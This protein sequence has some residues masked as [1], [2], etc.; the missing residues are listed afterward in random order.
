MCG[1]VGAVGDSGEDLLQGAAHRLLH[2]GP[3]AGG[4]WTEG[5]VTLAH[6]RLEVI[7]LGSPGTQPV[8]SASGRH[9]LVFNGEI[10]NHLAIRQGLSHLVPHWRGSSDS[11]T[12]IEALEAL[13]VDACLQQLVGMFAFALWDRRD[14]RL[15]LARDRLG[16][17]PLY[18]SQSGQSFAFASELEPLRVVLGEES[19]LQPERVD[20]DALVDLLSLGVTA[21]ERSI[22]RGIAKLRPGSVLTWCADDCDAPDV[23]E[24]EA[25]RYWSAPWVAGRV[26]DSSLCD[27]ESVELVDHAFTEAVRGQLMAEVPLGAFLSGG[28]DSSLVVA[29]MVEI[30]DGPVRTF[31]VGFESKD[32]DEA[33]YA[34]E[35]AGLLGTSHTE[36]YVTQDDLLALAPTLPFIGGEPFADPSMLPTL[37]VCALAR[38]HVTVALSG[39]GADELFAG[40]DRY[41]LSSSLERLPRVVRTLLETGV[42]VADH[43]WFRPLF[44]RTRRRRGDWRPGEHKMQLTS[45]RLRMLQSA[46]SGPHPEDRYLA[47][48]RSP[49]LN[50]LVRAPLRE[51]RPAEGRGAFADLDH[52]DAMLATDLR[53][54]LVDDI[55]VKVDRAAMHVSLETRMPFLDHRV[56][57]AAWRLSHRML[58][59]DGRTKWVLRE[60]LRRYVPPELTERPKAGF[61]V[62]LAAWLRGPLRPWAEELL[63]VTALDE[64]GLLETGEVRHLWREHSAGEADRSRELWPVLMFQGWIRGE[65]QPQP[66]ARSVSAGHR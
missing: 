56:V 63:A 29:K 28:I 27:E 46:L 65:P 11:E 5:D 23:T 1:F 42:R 38:E 35:I 64:H 18:F 16:E 4:A 3:D 53:E 32:H 14:R 34:R 6:R 43:E 30:S 19:R 2:R 44:E 31:S 26:R 58:V 22:V 55:L 66:V 17:K 15:V 9:V 57:E 62:P 59:R 25:Q 36:R 21:A 54:Y 40:Y 48:L 52:L 45:T 20:P 47:F 7:G 60:I 61:G 50:P 37:L 10:Y 51:P 24:M 39:D 8:H 41:R 12:L 49:L 33:P 13:G